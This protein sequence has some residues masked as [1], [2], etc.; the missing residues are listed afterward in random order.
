MTEAF[1]TMCNL[2]MITTIFWANIFV[3]FFYLWLIPTFGVSIWSFVKK[4]GWKI[5]LITF[6][7]NVAISWLIMM[8]MLMNAGPM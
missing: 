1:T 4:K 8:V 2:I 5:P 3:P 6:G 7:V